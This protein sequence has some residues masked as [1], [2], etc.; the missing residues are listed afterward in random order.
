MQT[1]S[2]VMAMWCRKSQ[3]P[4]SAK[5]HSNEASCRGRARDGAEAPHKRRV[6]LEDR[7]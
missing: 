3:R 5:S 2:A 4:T 7:T 6:G 1:F